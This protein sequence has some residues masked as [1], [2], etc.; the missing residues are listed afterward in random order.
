M[1]GRSRWQCLDWT[2]FIAS[3][4]FEYYIITNYSVLQYQQHVAIEP[5]WYSFLTSAAAIMR[6]GAKAKANMWYGET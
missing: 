4:I 2:P 1:F 6:F 5:L 3:Y